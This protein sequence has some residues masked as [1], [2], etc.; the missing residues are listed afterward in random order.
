MADK[1]SSFWW[2]KQIVIGLLALLFL[3]MGIDTLMN[4]Y[5]LNNPYYF[6]MYFFSSNLMILISAVGFL[7]P[8]MKIYQRFK[9]P[10]E[11]TE[12]EKDPS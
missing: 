6:I 4:A 12:K 1:P 2:A 3:F 11:G 9:C 7:W 5:R 8:V 10:T